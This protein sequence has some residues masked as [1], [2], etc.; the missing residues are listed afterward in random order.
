MNDEIEAMKRDIEFRNNEIK[1]I[2]EIDWELPE[3]KDIA[4]GLDGIILN[5][6]NLVKIIDILS[7][8]VTNLDQRVMTLEN[9]LG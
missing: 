1:R 9:Q 6:E 5:M 2:A 7:Q 4:R 3:L 8:E